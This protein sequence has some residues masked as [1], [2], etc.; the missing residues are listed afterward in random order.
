MLLAVLCIGCQTTESTAGDTPPIVAEESQPQ[1]VVTEH[2]T[3]NIPAQPAETCLILFPGMGGD[4]ARIEQE[5]HIPAM[6]MAENMT[7]A[8]MNM[9]QNLW[10]YPADLVHLNQLLE[11]ILDQLPEA[12]QRLAIG[13]FSSGGLVSMLWAQHLITEHSPVPIDKV[14]MVDSPTD[15]SAL[16]AMMQLDLTQDYP[17][18]RLEEPR[19][20]VNQCHAAFGQGDRLMQSLEAHSVYTH[21]TKNL[22]NISA[23]Q[24][25]DLRFY[26]E[27]DPAWWEE[28]RMVS[29]EGSNSFL[30]DQFET[31]AREAEWNNLEIIR[32]EN[33]GYRSNGER[34]PHSWSIVDAEDLLA[35]I[36]AGN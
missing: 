23:L 17:A 33:R 25:I 35:W 29:Y 13:G 5:S 27:P 32:T 22:Y 28:N 7:V 16:Y 2:Y 12:P 10:L 34:H 24:S 6:A 18:W 30:I 4:P 1:V 9:N 19:W 11:E 36:K 8:L 15:L 26:T 20:F 3:L 14:F 31:T 21:R